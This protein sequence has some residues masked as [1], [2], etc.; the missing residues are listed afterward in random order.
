MSFLKKIELGSGTVL[1]PSIAFSDDINLD[2][3]M[4]RISENNLGFTLGGVKRIDIGDPATSWTN[5]S[6]VNI[7]TSGTTSALNIYGDVTV[8][9]A[10]NLPGSLSFT[11]TITFTGVGSNVLSDGTIY[12]AP[13]TTNVVADNND[14]YF[15]VYTTP[16]LTSGNV[17]TVPNASTLY[18]AG[19]PIAGGSAT[20][21]NAYS[22]LVAAGKSYF[23]GQIL[24]SSGT[25]S[26]PGYGFIS[27]SGL[28]TGFYLIGEN[29]I[30]IT[31]DGIK[32]IDIGNTITSLTTGQTLNVG[33][34]GTT[35]P[36]N[37]FGL[38]TG[39][40]GLTISSGATSLQALT[41]SGLL[42]ANTGITSANG[43]IVN[44]GTSGIT[45]TLNVYGIS[46]YTNTATYTS[47][48]NTTIST[49]TFYVA[50]S[51]TNVPSSGNNYYFSALTAPDLTS[52]TAQTVNNAY[53][54]YIA[55]APTQSGSATI[56]NSYAL[57]VNSG[58]SYFGG[59]IQVASGSA[60]APAITFSTDSGLNTGF[61]RIGEDNIGIA[62][63]G[64]NR[65]DI[66]NTTTSFVTGH[67]V[68]IGTSGTTSPLNA[69]GLITGTN[70]LTIS[71]GATSLQALTTNGLLS[72]VLGITIT[73]GQTLNVGTS[74]TVSPLNVFGL[75]TGTNGLTISSGSSSLQALTTNGLLSAALGIT[76]TTGQTVNVGTSG[77]TS[78]LNVLGLIT[79]TNGLTISS[80]A[81]SLQA[82]TT[83]GLLT[84]NA[85]ITS[86]N[87]QIVNV[88]TSGISSTLNVFGPSNHSGIG[89]FTGVGNTAI[90][91]G[92]V[93][94]APVSTAVTG[95]NNYF[96]SS[97]AVPATTG[98]TTGSAYTMYI[99]G[100]PSGTITTPYSLYVNAG[101]SY[102][103]G[104]LQVASGS[105]S[106]PAITFSTD[107]GLNTGFYRIGE[108]NIGIA[109][110]GSNRID[111]GNTTTSFV[112]GHIVNVGTSGISSTL[113]V[114]G[115]SNHSGIG[116]FTGIG[117]TT[118]ATGSVY[119]APVSTAVTGSNNYFFSSF[120]VPATTGS[121][122]G[123][124]YT[125][126]IAGAPS[127]TIT[128]PFAFYIAAGK[129]YIGGALQIPTG[130]ITNYHLTS[131]ATGNATWQ[132]P[133]IPTYTST[134]T[135]VITTNAVA[136][137]PAIVTVS[138]GGANME[139]TPESGTYSF[140]FNAGFRNTNNI[141]RSGFFQF[142]KNSTAIAA[143]INFIGS[144]IT[145]NVSIIIRANISCNGTDVIGVRWY[146]SNTS[147]SM[148]DHVLNCF[149]TGA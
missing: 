49:G 84:A 13:A 96:F 76:V 143:Y 66:G 81:T 59:Q 42:T 139:V 47:T 68:N 48:G 3:G 77:T 17:W 106:A 71:S 33:T 11:S 119:V 2:T 123:S 52:G 72:A 36:L 102:F 63:N 69:F 44:I 61:Y 40:N 122:T 116:T 125:V 46:N 38:I 7:G 115:P 88:G 18:I 1:L 23:G 73:T 117:N 79:G 138:A 65:I 147:S 98:S 105:A 14:H 149:R 110:N 30:G 58:V 101:I 92:S 86:V 103:G 133:T 80:G 137:S 126:Y 109:T 41:T 26:L 19:A 22:L 146:G 89:T 21:T 34:S 136:A 100:A 39:T 118:N 144:S 43:Q 85:G 142:T 74:S 83:N 27:D 6:I 134:A 130:A 114:F 67:T 94:V 54:M 12:V 87:G 60:S 37:V 70:G 57:L 129:S 128:T 95:S 55:G 112:N 99:A 91:S 31:T 82:L 45:S 121:T 93:Y 29:N 120:A 78:P 32:R 4:Y 28:N 113:N 127:G 64:S 131:D 97:F 90:A 51:S 108:D 135:G 16:T 53:T 20:I 35:S 104:Q 141:N 148:S 8:Y 145:I 75:I 5:G 62:T 132:R 9:G 24:A 10:L 111:I 50:P 15:S 124:A 25:V 107:T 56:T 140:T